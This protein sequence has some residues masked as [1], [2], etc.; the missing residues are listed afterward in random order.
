MATQRMKPFADM[1]ALVRAKVGRF[2][3]SEGFRTKGF[4]FR[5]SD[6][7]GTRKGAVPEQAFLQTMSR[8]EFLEAVAAKIEKIAVKLEKTYPDFSKKLIEDAR[9]AF[10]AVADV[11]DARA[12][13][14]ECPEA[15][16]RIGALLAEP[17]LF[18]DSLKS[19]KIDFNA[20]RVD[21][22]EKAG[23]L[24]DDIGE[25]W[26]RICSEFPANWKKLENWL[27]TSVE[28]TKETKRKQ[29]NFVYTFASDFFSGPDNGMIGWNEVRAMEGFNS[30]VLGEI[31]ATIKLMLDKTPLEM[32]SIRKEVA[33]LAEDLDLCA[34][35]PSIEKSSRVIRLPHPQH[36]IRPSMLMIPR[37]CSKKSHSASRG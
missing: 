16:D 24:A 13:G 14:R 34:S 35:K 7:P 12:E 17:N 19:C 29:K 26:R 18:I 1:I 10:T 4:V 23:M 33:R 37:N 8:M 6:E 15:M 36:G 25:H 27:K 21:T 2:L 32:T 9:A 5:F 3:E 20:A 28:S 22:L 30:K 31:G 11:I